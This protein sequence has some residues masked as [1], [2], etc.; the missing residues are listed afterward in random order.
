MTTFDPAKSG[1]SRVFLIEGGPRPDHEP[2]FQACLVAGAIERSFGDV[3]DIECPDPSEY[4]NFITVGQIRGADERATVTLNGRYAVDVAS[5]LLRLAQKKCEVDV[6]IHFGADSNPSEFRTFTKALVLENAILQDWSTDELGALE[7]GNQNPVG[8]STNVSAADVWEVLPITT[9]QRA[10]DITLNEIVDITIYD[11][12]SCGSGSRDDSDGCQRVFAVAK[13]TVG[14]PGTPP[15]LLYSLTG[16]S[17]WQTTEVDTLTSAE[18]P[19]GVAGVGGYIVVI[20]EDADSL[21]YADRDDFDGTTNPTWTEVTTGV[22]AAGSPRAIYSVDT[23]AFVAGEGGYVYSFSDPGSGLTALDE[24]SATSDDLADVHAL[25]ENLAVA[26]GAN[27]SVV[28]TTDGETWSA[29]SA[30]PSAN[31]LTAVLMLSE[32]VWLVG[33]DAGDLYYT[34]N[35]GS[36][37]TAKAFPG[38]G[39]GSVIDLAAS[40]AGGVWLSHQT[41]ATAGRL[42]RSYDGGHQWLVMPENVG[43]IPANDKITALATCEKDANLCIGGGLADDAAAGIIVL[44]QD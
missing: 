28:Y 30:N 39:S 14:S 15:D 31:G 5:E 4:G 7:S 26:V 16:G 42:L 44:A 37:W 19:T 1:F 41:A 43:S 29:T 20:S 35:S 24:G 10:S 36:S 18:D 12:S 9:S 40:P 22:V 13:A 6:H 33:D 34:T 2:D 17:T 38:S 25:S 3:T 8:E 27:G 21:S 23:L 11:S 32:S